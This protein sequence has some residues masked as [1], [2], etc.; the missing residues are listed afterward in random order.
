MLYMDIMAAYCE[1]HTEHTNT[2]CGQ[3]VMTGQKSVTLQLSVGQPWCRA[4]FGAHDH[5]LKLISDTAPKNER[6]N[7]EG[8]SDE[9]R[10]PGRRQ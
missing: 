4:P 3:S 2:V 10:L 7:T 5:I 9:R 1:N 6:A 8:R